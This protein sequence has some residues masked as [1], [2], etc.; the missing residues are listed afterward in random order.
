[1]V[2]QFEMVFCLVTGASK[3]SGSPAPALARFPEMSHLCVLTFCQSP[4]GPRAGA[5]GQPF[6]R[7][8]GRRG[9]GRAGTGPRSPHWRPA[10]ACGH[11]RHAQGCLFCPCLSHAP[12]ILC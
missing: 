12:R 2:G 11:V 3:L 5:V 10:G 8:S 1:M 4:W 6:P 9:G 7:G